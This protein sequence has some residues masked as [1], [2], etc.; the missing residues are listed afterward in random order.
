MSGNV[1]RRREEAAAT[2]VHKQNQATT[3][4]QVASVLV[5]VMLVRITFGIFVECTLLC[6]VLANPPF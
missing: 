3:A 2:A 4:M 5:C 1:Q 6:L